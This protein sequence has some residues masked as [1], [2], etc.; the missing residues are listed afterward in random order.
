M[1]DRDDS[2][3]RDR[4]QDYCR[5]AYK[6][7]NHRYKRR[8]RDYYED[9]YENRHHLDKYEYQFINDRYDIITGRPK[10]KHCTHG[11]KSDSFYA[12]LE[13]LYSSMGT[14]DELQLSDICLIEKYILD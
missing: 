6:D 5:D 7:E 12:E 2:Y 1:Y 11:D 9:T 13:E 14:V 3:S 4:S 10:E 8:S